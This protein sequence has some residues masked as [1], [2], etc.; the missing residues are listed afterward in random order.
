MAEASDNEEELAVCKM[1]CS[2]LNLVDENLRQRE[3]V[4]QKFKSE[5]VGL[6]I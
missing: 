1:Y 2:I 6:V 5:K 3:N 4:I